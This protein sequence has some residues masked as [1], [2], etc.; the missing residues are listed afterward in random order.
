MIK[1]GDIVYLKR[2]AYLTAIGHIQGGE[3]P[4]LIV[5]NDK[6]NSSSQIVIAVPLTTNKRRLD[7]PTHTLVTEKSVALCEQIFTFNQAFIDRKVDHIKAETMKK[8]E[9]CLAAS[10]GMMI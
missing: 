10:L 6:G 2:G 1:R 4:M 3:R 8:V 9:K 5:S 7:L